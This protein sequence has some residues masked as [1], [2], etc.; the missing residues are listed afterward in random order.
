MWVRGAAIRPVP[1]YA[2][3]ERR[4]LDDVESELGDDDS[5]LGDALDRFERTQ[6]SLSKRA[7]DLVARPLDETARA[8]GYFLTIA[9]WLSFERTFGKRLSEVTQEQ[10]EAAESALALEE[11]LRAAHA[12]EPLDLEDV[13]SMEQP[14]VIAFVHEYIDAALDP[15]EAE[16]LP[17]D[18][19][20]DDVHAVYR[21]VL[22]QTLALSH[23]VDPPSGSR[24]REL[25]A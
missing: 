21:L 2:V 9:V 18:V 25:L 4:V 17:R 1:G 22:I 20:V 16:D 3:V 7:A 24:T 8:L 5:E 14:A 10:V 23:A 13:M 19:D 6:R 15:T 12:D 11:E